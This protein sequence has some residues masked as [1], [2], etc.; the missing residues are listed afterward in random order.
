MCNHNFTANYDRLP[1]S[2][3]NR[4]PYPGIYQKELSKKQSGTAK[5]DILKL[6]VDKQGVCIFHSQD[7]AWKMKND[8]ANHFLQ[9]LKLIEIDESQDFYDFAEFRFVG[10][11]L[12]TKRGSDYHVLHISDINFHKQVYFTGA[13]FLNELEMDNVAF[14][15]G[16]SFGQSSFL[17]NLSVN[18]ARFHGV[19]FGNSQ[20]SQLAFFSHVKFL[21]YAL[22]ENSNF[23]GDVK[24]YDSQFEGLTDFSGASFNPTGKDSSMRFIKVKFEDN[25]DFK[26]AKFY[27]HIVFENVSFASRTTFID[28]LFDTVKSSATYRGSSAEFNRIILRN[29]AE[30]VFKSTDPSKKMFNDNVQMSFLEEPEGIIWFENVNFSQF[31]LDSKSRLIKLEKKGKV[32]IGSGCRKYKIQTAHRTIVISNNNAPLVLEIC[33]TFTNYF[34]VSNGFNLGFE[35]VNRNKTEISFYYFTDENISEAIFF[36]R[37]AKTEQQVLSLLSITSIDQVLDLKTRPVAVQSISTK[38]VIINTIDGISALLGT[39]FRVG[40]R[41]ALGSWGKDDTKAL[42]GAIRFNDDS[43]DARDQLIHQVLVAKYTNESIFNINNLLNDKL[44]LNASQGDTYIMGDM[45]YNVNGNSN[46]QIVFAQNSSYINVNQGKS[47]IDKP[48]DLIQLAN[49]LSMLRKTMIQEA[50]EVEQHISV[51][52]VARAEQSARDKD[53]SGVVKHLKS[54]GK[55]T[56]DVAQ[57]IGIPL[58]TEV[59]KDSLRLK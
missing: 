18:N 21:S 8:F 29:K 12:R 39:F 42:L 35:V 56:L 32:E 55:W 40:A 58:A 13:C 6:P 17:K 19:E 16:A 22:F 14:E 5:R 59:L 52:D 34:T 7:V 53:S 48:L 15:G 27:N 44:K 24:F 11:E 51:G 4:C 1:K 47:N 49:E 20:F 10:N 23:T 3:G 41:I 37:L 46:S 28:T 36:E 2:M 26:D 33:Q 45:N 31:D 9:L 57:K 30:L 43:T 25:T 54:A 50:I 38:T